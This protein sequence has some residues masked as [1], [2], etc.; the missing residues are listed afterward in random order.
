[1]SPAGPAEPGG[2]VERWH[3]RFAVSGGVVQNTGWQ[4]ADRV[5]RLGLSFAVGVWVVRYLGPVAFGQLSYALA[6]VSLFSPLVGL[7]LDTILVRELVR[8]PTRSSEILGSAFGLRLAGSLLAAIAAVVTIILVRHDA[9]MPTLVLIAVAALPFQSLG[10]IE[11]WFQ[12]QLTVKYAVMARNAALVV[13]SLARVALIMAAFAVAA[14]AVVG[15][16]E[17]ALGA[18][19]LVL[20]Y[21]W[22]G[23]DLSHWR[24]SWARA[25]SLLRDS[26]PLIFSNAMIMLY[27]RID[28]LMLGQ[29]SGVQELGRLL[30]GGAAHRGLVRAADGGDVPRCS[31]ASCARAR[32][33]RRSSTGG[34]S[35]STT[36]WRCAATPSRCRQR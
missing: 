3:R 31:R 12:S 7:G 5:V 9:I 15:S 36:S 10:V 17:V 30:S 29:M 24:F 2:L 19:A 26:W 13:A 25:R 33:A 35:V 4:L 1:M 20:A 22:T 14:F 8:E 32:R 23:R 27:M 28:Q 18:T 6:F 34:S 16:A 11:Q 21:V